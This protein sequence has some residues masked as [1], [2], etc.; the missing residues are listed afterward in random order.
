MAKTLEGITL[1]TVLDALREQGIQAGQRFS[2]T[3]DQST[4]T[5][6]SLTEIAAKMQAAAATRGLTSEIFD[7]LIAQPE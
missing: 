3:V 6:P 4:A 5:R 2:I 1:D 7:K